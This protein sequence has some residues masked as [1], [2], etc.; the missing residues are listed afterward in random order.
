[1]RSLQTYTYKYKHAKKSHKIMGCCSSEIIQNQGDLSVQ[2]RTDLVDR[3]KREKKYN[4]PC[5]IIIAYL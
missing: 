2:L 4:Q 1:M 3:L 5:F